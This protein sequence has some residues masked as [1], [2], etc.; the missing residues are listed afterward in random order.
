[1][2]LENFVDLC[3]VIVLEIGL[4]GILEIKDFLLSVFYVRYLK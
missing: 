4:E 3:V 2:W 1:M